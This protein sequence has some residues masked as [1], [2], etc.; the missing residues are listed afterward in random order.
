MDQVNV[1]CGMQDAELE[2]GKASRGRSAIRNL[3]CHGIL[4]AAA[5]LVWVYTTLS[6][7]GCWA[8]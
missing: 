6:P 7:K 2:N 5:G 3:F 4:F 8:I 1:D